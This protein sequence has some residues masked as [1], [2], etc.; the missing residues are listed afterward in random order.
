MNDFRFSINPR[1]RELPECSAVLNGRVGLRDYVVHDYRTT[2]SI[3]SVTRGHAFYRTP[4]GRFRVD[5]ENFLVLNRGQEY[6]LEI[7][8]GTHTETLC[9]FF[10]PGLIEHVIGNRRQT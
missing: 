3:K 6:S 5:A 1:A 7:P 2:L 9:L 10:Q 8:A 4:N